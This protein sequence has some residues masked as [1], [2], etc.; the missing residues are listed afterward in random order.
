MTDAII[1]EALKYLYKQAHGLYSKVK[2]CRTLF[3]VDPAS[4]MLKDTRHPVCHDEAMS[5]RIAGVQVKGLVIDGD[6]TPTWD[7]EVVDAMLEWVSTFFEFE[8]EAILKKIPGPATNTSI[9]YFKGA[10]KRMH[11]QFKTLDV[12]DLIIAP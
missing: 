2:N 7:S 9:K 4:T 12:N 10:Q 3:A 6:Q 11:A 5:L 8:E 1:T